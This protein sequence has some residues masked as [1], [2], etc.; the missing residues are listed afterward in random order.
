VYD[1]QRTKVFGYDDQG[2]YR[3]AWQP[4][5]FPGPS[6]K[7]AQSVGRIYLASL[8]ACTL[9]PMNKWPVTNAKTDENN[10]QNC[11]KSQPAAPGTR[12][13][14]PSNGLHT[15]PNFRSDHPSGC[16]FLFA[17]GSVHFLQ[18]DIDMLTYQ[19][20]ST[21]AGGEIAELPSD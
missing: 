5:E 11:A 20:L 19:Q 3:Q 12:P 6:F 9:E 14:L 2:Q 21:H 18:E 8:M 7:L 15:A 10:L 1:N 17:D 16:N 13:I 4:W